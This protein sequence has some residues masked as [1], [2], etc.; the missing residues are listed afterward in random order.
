MREK[1]KRK[2]I[3]LLEQLWERGDCSLDK[4]TRGYIE[5]KMDELL[6]KSASL[7]SIEWVK[8]EVSISSLRDLALGN[9]IGHLTALATTTIRLAT[10]HRFSMEDYKTIR[11]MVKRRLPE[12]VEKIERELGR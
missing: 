2:L 3:T 8:D 6:Q 7:P 5:S 11:E 12:I 4:V 10:G 1:K 9:D